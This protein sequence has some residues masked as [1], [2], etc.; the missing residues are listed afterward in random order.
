[1]F[2]KIN[3]KDEYVTVIAEGRTVVSWYNRENNKVTVLIL[4][5][6]FFNAFLVIYP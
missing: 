1:M 3:L 4:R 2:D 6:F 5:I